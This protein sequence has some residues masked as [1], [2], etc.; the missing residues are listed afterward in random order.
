MQGLTKKQREIVDFIESYATEK[1]CSPS[2]REIQDFFGFASLGSV[3]NHIQTLKRKGVVSE[4]SKGARSLKLQTDP[5]LETVPLIGKLRG[6]SAIET[7]AQIVSVHFPSPPSEECYLLT[8]ADESLLEEC[9]QPDDLVLVAPRRKFEEGE[10]VIA[11]IDEQITLV[12]R[13]YSE[14]PYIR[15]ESVSPH[16]QPLMVRE[17][18]VSIQGT[19]LTLLRNY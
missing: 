6:G 19:I 10:L 1:R 16:V 12:K 8:V 5:S 14:P 2:Y 7:F 11:L 3:Y 17:D 15:F 18:H 9:L 4:F 13:A